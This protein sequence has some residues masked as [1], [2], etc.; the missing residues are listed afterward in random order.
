MK[1]I[2]ILTIIIITLLFNEFVYAASA[3]RSILV[4]NINTITGISD[5]KFGK[6]RDTLMSAGFTVDVKNRI[7]VP[8]LTEALLS[9][10]TQLWLMETDASPSNIYA[11]SEQEKKYIWNFVD[12]T[13]GLLIAGEEDL[14]FASQKRK[15]GSLAEAI[16]EIVGGA[17]LIVGGIILTIISFG[18]AT[19]LIPVGN[20]LITTGISSIPETH[21]W[22]GNANIFSG[23]GVSETLA[24]IQYGNAIS[25]TN[26]INPVAAMFGVVYEGLTDSHTCMTNIHDIQWSGAGLAREAVPDLRGRYEGVYPPFCVDGSVN[27][28]GG[29]ARDKCPCAQIEPRPVAEEIINP[30]ILENVRLLYI[31]GREPLL[32]PFRNDINYIPVAFG[33]RN[34]ADSKQKHIIAIGIPHAA[35]KE[36]AFGNIFFDASWTRYTNDYPSQTVN[37]IL[38]GDT[39][40]YTIEV[41]RWIEPSPDVYKPSCKA[42]GDWRNGD[43]DI[44]TTVDNC[45][46]DEK[47]GIV[48]PD[49]R[50]LCTTP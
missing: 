37:H 33:K 38:E 5:E 48:T 25:F 39:A 26:T 29:R 30:G 27:S 13:G 35:Y 28:V 31:D 24:E 18:V 34:R 10:Y 4:Y 1:I 8:E 9:K 12:R 15:S 2:K 20:A 49:K 45:C 40:K 36:G 47:K 21:S 19:P 23:Q 32:I 50:F 41:A 42:I 44:S 16:I 6:L 22:H 3:S 46:W 17:I 11:F 7:E 14:S 43:N